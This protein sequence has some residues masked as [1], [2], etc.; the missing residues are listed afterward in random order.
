MLIN[1]ITYTMQHI[2]TDL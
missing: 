2:A 1:N